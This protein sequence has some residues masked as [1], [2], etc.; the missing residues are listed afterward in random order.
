[1]IVMVITAWCISSEE[2]GVDSKEVLS[3]ERVERAE[4]LAEPVN[5][6]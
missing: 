5:S 3:E 6:P 4:V 1:M 2:D